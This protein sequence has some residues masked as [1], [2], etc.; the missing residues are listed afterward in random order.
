MGQIRKK[1]W[2]LQQRTNYE[3]ESVKNDSKVSKS[4]GKVGEKN[5]ESMNDDGE[6]RVMVNSRLKQ[7]LFD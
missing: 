6:N 2:G 5:P 3:Y 1:N 7:F 4:P